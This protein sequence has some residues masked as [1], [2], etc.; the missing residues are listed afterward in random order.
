MKRLVSIMKSFQGDDLLNYTLLYTAHS[1]ECGNILFMY[2]KC[3]DL[4]I[5]KANG[6]N[7]N[8]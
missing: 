7:V 4:G 2:K 6:L 1:R 8:T 3:V 5:L